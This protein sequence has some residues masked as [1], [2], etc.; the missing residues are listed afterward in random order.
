MDKNVTELIVAWDWQQDVVLPT[1]FIEHKCE[2]GKTKDKIWHTFI[3]TQ[4][5]LLSLF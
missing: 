3:L 5:Y 1:H 2:M 4:V